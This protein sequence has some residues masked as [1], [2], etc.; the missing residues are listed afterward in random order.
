MDLLCE[1]TIQAVPVTCNSEI[2]AR[3]NRGTMGSSMYRRSVH[4]AIGI[5]A[6]YLKVENNPT[7]Y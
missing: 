2:L 3:L 6:P 1:K 7:L 5:P 4:E